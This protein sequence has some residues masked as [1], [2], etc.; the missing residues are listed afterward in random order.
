MP[1]TL[2][3]TKM[4]RNLLKTVYAPVFCFVLFCFVFFWPGVTELKFLKSVISE[5]S[6]FSTTKR[7]FTVW[8][9]AWWTL[10]FSINFEKAKAK[11]GTVHQYS[12][13]NKVGT[14]STKLS[15]KKYV[16]FFS[17]W[18]CKKIPKTDFITDP[19]TSSITHG[20]VHV[21]KDLTSYLKITSVKDVN[22][23]QRLATWPAWHFDP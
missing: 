5:T 20:T 15:A 7:D 3:F 19:W 4:F 2:K 10:S 12:F 21:W 11:Q 8:N 22:I 23:L 13:D 1:L 17:T 16:K 18:S 14:Q 9:W 6:D